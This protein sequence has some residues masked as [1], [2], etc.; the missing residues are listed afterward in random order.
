MVLT[1][2]H[3]NDPTSTS[4]DH[5]R[6]YVPLLYLGEKPGRD[7]GLRASFNDHAATVAAYFG[8]PY[9]TRGEAFD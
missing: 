8:V 2:D 5:S 3:G 6:E 1:A 7:L 4:T 9:A